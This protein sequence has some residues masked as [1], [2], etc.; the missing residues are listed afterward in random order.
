[1]EKSCFCRNCFIDCTFCSDLVKYSILDGDYTVFDN[2]TVENRIK[3][4]CLSFFKRQPFGIC[5]KNPL[6]ATIG[7][8][9]FSGE[10]QL[11]CG[12][13]DIFFLQ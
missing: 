8:T 7:M 10:F 9:M 13:L 2:G 3:N 6:S 4:G 5:E 11:E 12:V 1:M